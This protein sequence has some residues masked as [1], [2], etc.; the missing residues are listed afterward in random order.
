M[1]NRSFARAVTAG[2]L[3]LVGM[4]LGCDRAPAPTAPA[5]VNVPVGITAVAPATGLTGDF[6]SITGSGFLPGVVVTLDGTPAPIKGLS[7]QGTEIVVTTPLHAAATVDVVV[8]N[9]GW[10][11]RRR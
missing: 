4:S 10:P 7:S 6:V 9:A 8:T 3:G 1:S 5:A 11:E 2:L